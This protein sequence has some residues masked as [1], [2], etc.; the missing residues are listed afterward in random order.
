[1]KRM[2]IAGL[3]AILC[4]LTAATS[5]G[6]EPSVFSKL[7]PFAKDDAPRPSKP[8]D[9]EGGLHFPKLPAPKLPKVDL[10]PDWASRSPRRSNEPSAWSRMTTGTKNLFS[11]TAD[12]LNPFDDADDKKAAA[13]PSWRNGSRSK[14]KPKEKK[15]L[16]LPT[17]LG[18]QPEEER[19]QTVNDFLALPRPSF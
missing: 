13:A 17:W 3:A 10:T 11:K 15:G 14:A 1:M 8:A 18:G 2:R 4:V 12:V 9:D 16:S 19:P 5:R 7:N 6:D